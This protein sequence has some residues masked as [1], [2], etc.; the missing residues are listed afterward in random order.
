MSVSDRPAAVTYEDLDNAI[1]KFSCQCT[2]ATYCAVNH[3]NLKV[4]MHRV[5]TKASVSYDAEA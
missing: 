1:S 5:S 4:M 3:G 2:T